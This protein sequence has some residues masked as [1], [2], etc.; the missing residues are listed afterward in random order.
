ME[1]RPGGVVRGRR[2]WW[3]A[4]R[5]VL[6]LG[7][8]LLA[9]EASRLLGGRDVQAAFQNAGKLLHAERTLGLPGERALQDL[10]LHAEPLV[11]AANG[12]YA[13]AHLS[14]TALALLW[15]FLAHPAVY[16]RTRQAL[17]GVTSVALTVY[18]LVPVAPPRMLPGFVDTAAVLGPSVY[19]D[20]GASALT[21]QYAALPSLHV[22]WALLVAGAC[23]S[24]GCTRWRWLWL[25]H[26]VVTVLVVVGTGNHYWLD[27][28]AAAALVAVAWATTGHLQPPRRYSGPATSRRRHARPQRPRPPCPMGRRSRSSGPAQGQLGP[29]GSGVPTNR[30]RN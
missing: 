30:C 24:A 20:A 8:G 1:Q 21:N 25:L 3:A 7:G 23:T 29:V 27:A 26:P 5:E 10:L 13:A 11:R 19:G 17:L 15:L 6:L 2:V 16:R 28:G 4:G 14:V 18:L 22:G 9:Y 12:F